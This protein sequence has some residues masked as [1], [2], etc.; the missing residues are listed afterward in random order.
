MN[1]N[2]I[3]L[4]TKSVNQIDWFKNLGNKIEKQEMRDI[5]TYTSSFHDR[6]T[7]KNVHNWSETKS[8]LT[9]Q[10]FS[11]MWNKKE[12]LF[13]SNLYKKALKY[14]KEKELLSSLK[15]LNESSMHPLYM[16]ASSAADT[17][18]LLDTSLTKCAAGAASLS[19]YQ[20]AIA[21][22]AGCKSEHPFLAKYR[23]FSNGR[24]PLSIIKGY[25]YIF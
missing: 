25:F 8:V 16:A 9:N 12:L 3:E 22:A 15:D 2:S 19:C 20:A 1:I 23:L 11:K 21:I 5:K 6:I 10:N 24:W 13:Q 17:F 18:K 7:C 14:H 4:I